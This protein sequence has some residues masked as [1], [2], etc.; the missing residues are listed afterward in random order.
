MKAQQTFKGTSDISG[1]QMRVKNAVLDI[2]RDALELF[3]FEPLETPIIERTET[4]MGK[5][6]DEAE[7]LLF[8]L[9]K[10]HDKGGLRYDHTVPLARFA[11]SNWQSLQK[12]FKRYSIGPNFRAENPQAGRYRQFTQCDFDTLGADSLV[13]DAEIAAVNYTI[14]TRLGFKDEFLIQFNDR[15]LLNNLVQSLGFEGGNAN[16]VFRGWDKL[17]KISPQ[18]SLEYIKEN[19]S[20]V[21]KDKVEKLSKLTSDLLNAKPDIQKRIGVIKKYTDSKEVLFDLERIERLDELIESLGVPRER[22]VFNPLLARGLSYYT[23][24]IFETILPGSK[25]GSIT[26]GG[27]YDNLIKQM[28]GPDVP[29]C[30]SAFGVERLIMAMDE[31][32]IKLNNLSG[33]QILVSVFS[34]DLLPE[35]A[36]IASILRKNGIKTEL[37]SDTSVGMPKQFKYADRKNIDYVVVIGP[38]EIKKGKISVKDMRNGKQKGMN[39]EELVKKLSS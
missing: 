6:G 12:P 17:D 36:R 7:N 29:A 16:S 27:R 23:G 31:A 2:V 26:G 35:S 4:L 34:G 39:V 21:G 15:T 20:G 28:G 5:Y 13:A 8:K 19:V 11:A 1:E 24:P 9:A 32:G 10:P 3:G 14:L 18:K 33:N 38:E 22:Y 25:L 30:G 37:Y